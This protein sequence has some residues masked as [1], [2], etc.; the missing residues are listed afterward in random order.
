M[1]LM[2]ELVQAVSSGDVALA[3]QMWRASDLGP[4]VTDSPTGV[5]GTP[6]LAYAIGQA[7]KGFAR[8]LLEAGA[9]ANLRGESGATPMFFVQDAEGVDLLRAFGGNPNVSL[10][11][12]GYGLSRGGR[13]LHRVA[14]MSD[15][16]L[17]RAL[18]DAGAEVG[19]ADRYGRT[20]MHY[21][22]R[23]SGDIV[24][25]LH[26]AGASLDVPD[27]RGITP[28]Q[29]VE[30]IFPDFQME[31]KV[32]NAAV[33]IEQGGAGRTGEL[34]DGLTGFTYTV[35]K[36]LKTAEGDYF[37]VGRENG[38]PGHIAFLP[39][40]G[41][42]DGV[43]DFESADDLR[44]WLAGREAVEAR[45][46]QAFLA[47]SEAEKAR[48]AVQTAA[49][50]QQVAAAVENSIAPAPVEN[51]ADALAARLKGANWQYAY[52][53]DPAVRASG[54]AAAEAIFKDLAAFAKAD[55]AGALRLWTEHGPKSFSAPAYLREAVALPM[56]RVDVALP[57]AAIT[58]ADDHARREPAGA[59][60]RVENTIQVVPE[61][62]ASLVLLDVFNGMSDYVQAL[63]AS[64]D[65]SVTEEMR[66]RLKRVYEEAHK[67]VGPDPA[68]ANVADLDAASDLLWNAYE[69][70]V[71][72]W[73]TKQKGRE[74]DAWFPAGKPNGNGAGKE[75]GEHS[76]SLAAEPVTLLGGRFIRGENGEYRRQGETR[77]A[78]VDE[79]E[80]IRFV[81]KQMD[82][83]QA[84]VELAKAKEWGA[85]LVTGTEKFRGEAW[86][87]ASMAG[88]KVVGY[89]PTEKDLAT[90]K[91]ARE[92]AAKD[93]VSSPAR[94][95][96]AQAVSD[97][98][99][100][101]K[102]LKAANE[103]A[104]EA[105][106]VTQPLNDHSGRYAGKVLH[107][108]E[109]HVVQDVGRKVAVVHEKSA[110]NAADLKKAIER[111]GSLRVQYDN[112][113]AAIDTGKGRAQGHT[114]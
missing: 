93:G 84:A 58:T 39:A 57:A 5:G 8:E 70:T 20:A 54:R 68:R 77:V 82:A 49:K 94:V 112:G 89:E 24:R 36:E 29:W 56:A 33:V 102:S 95:G 67:L 101:A 12:S 86:Y 111:G 16:V 98:G 1:A 21:G 114:R 87:H 14:T 109:H 66:S 37:F 78:L 99:A 27:K 22:A 3:R 55:Q 41:P 75:V 25:V 51:V 28:R 2:D 26:G 69:S 4:D 65:K 60:S 43:R 64:P 90:L 7:D 91:Q 106:G 108:T 46:V 30:R 47:L 38:Q 17:V 23:V 88:M 97:A 71:H 50:A 80:K 59:E 6:L 53:D 19:A 63:R 61:E 34:A 74:V 11:R 104:L 96:A 9:D 105:V 40:N 103:F 79:V 42:L 32:A 107:E 31:A 48:D 72:E 18:I 52:A 10:K 44:T 113:R 73:Q 45:A 76:E 13:P 35:G 15:P 83:F 81:D 62:S 92:S 110:F 100:K 85:I